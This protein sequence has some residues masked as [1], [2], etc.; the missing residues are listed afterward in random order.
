MRDVVRTAGGEDADRFLDAWLRPHVPVNYALRKVE[1]D[2]AGKPGARFTIARMSPEARPD[3]LEVALEEDGDAEPETSFVDLGGPSNAVEL[4]ASKKVRAL[5]LDPERKTVETRLDDDRVPSEYQFLLD[6]ADVEVS[7]TEFG[8]STLLV[9]RRR[10]DYQKDLAAAGFYT[11]RGYGVDAGLQLH[12][13]KP[14]DANLYRQ[15]LFAYDPIEELDSSFENKQAPDVRTR[16]RLGGFGLRFNSYDA[17]WFENPAG[18]HHL[19]LFFDGYDRALGG[20]F[21]FVRG[22]GSLAYTLP[23]R[24]DTVAAQVLNGYSAATGHGP[25]PNQ[26]LFSLGGI[27]FDPRHRS[28]RRARQGYR[29]GARGAPSHAALAARLEL[30]GR[31]DRTPAAGKGLRG[32]RARRKLLAAALRSIRVRSRRRRRAEP[33]LR[34]HGIL[35]DHVLSRRRHARRQGR[36]GASAVRRR[37]ASESATGYRLPAKTSRCLFR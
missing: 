8:I 11:S 32:Y 18:S 13:G 37:P 19:R 33:V 7:S 31:V 16:G 29:R 30:R 23:L 35:P 24:E 25:I 5:Q 34:L 27:P 21:G 1:L 12:G 4:T 26:G 20:D 10:Y 9:G 6:S 3:S 28:G 2:P 15:N 36:Q 17:F 14:I 22:G